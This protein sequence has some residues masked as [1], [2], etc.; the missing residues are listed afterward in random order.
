MTPLNRIKLE[1]LGSYRLLVDGQTAV[2]P[3]Y[4]KAWALLAYFALEP[5]LHARDKLVELLGIDSLAHLRQLL[6]RLR[7]MLDQPGLPAPFHT[8]HSLIGIATQYPLQCDARAFLANAGE[9]LPLVEQEARLALYRG[10]FLQG[11]SLPDAPEFETWQT[12]Q[13]EQARQQAGRLMLALQQ[14][15]ETRGQLPEAL[16]LA[17]RQVEL[18]P[19]NE[20]SHREVI[21]LLAANGQTAAALAHY[22]LCAQTLQSALNIAPGAKTQALY[23]GL[24]AGEN[25]LRDNAPPHPGDRT[26]TTEKRLITVLCLEVGSPAVTV[27]S[28][29]WDSCLS[30]M[31]AIEHLASARHTFL[32]LARQQLLDAGAYCLPEQGGRLLAYF[33]YPVARENAARQAV[34]LALELSQL[35]SQHGIDVRLGCHSALVLADGK[36]TPDMASVASGQAIQLTAQTAPGHCQISQ[37]TATL[38]QG[39]F[40]LEENP[41]KLHKGDHT[42]TVMAVTGKVHRLDAIGT[43]YPL[44]PLI[45]REQELA[46]LL[47]LWHNLPAPKAQANTDPTTKTNAVFSCLVEGE[48]GIGKSRLLRSLS[49]LVKLRQGQVIILYCQPEYAQ[50]PFQPLLGLFA[51]LSAATEN[52]PLLDRLEQLRLWMGRH[53]PERQR[54]HNETSLALLAD[55]FGMRWPQHQILLD[56]LLPQQRKDGLTTLLGDLLCGLALAQPLLL[57]VEDLHWCDPSTLDLLVR[58]AQTAPQVALL[59]VLTT[60]PHCA[61]AARLHHLAPRLVLPPLNAKEVSRLVLAVAG[62]LPATAVEHI[63]VCAE[64]VPL[65]A[66][67]MARM[68]HLDTTTM[69]ASVGSSTG[70]VALFTLQELLTARLDACGS[71]RR[72]AQLAANIGRDFS[73]KLLQQISPL[74]THLLSQELIAL[75]AAGL[76]HASSQGHYQFKHALIQDAAYASQPRSVQMTAHRRIAQALQQPITDDPAVPPEILAHHLTAAG[77]IAAALPFWRAAGQNAARQSASREAENLYQRGIALLP[78]DFDLIVNPNQR[79]ALLREAFYLCAAHGSIRLALFGYGSAEARQ[80]FARAVALSDRLELLYLKIGDPGQHQHELHNAL[81]PVLFGLWHGGGENA[82]TVAPLDLAERLSRLADSS[83]DPAQRLV[84]DYAFSHNYFWLGRYADARRHQE[85][86]IQNLHGIGSETLIALCGEDSTLLSASFLAWTLCFQGYPARAQTL[87]AETV[88]A[89]RRTE[90]THTLCY[91]LIFAGVLSRHLVQ[92]KT[93]LSYAREVTELAD[94]HSLSLWQ[95]AANALTGWALGMQGDPAGIT[96]MRRGIEL[97]RGAMRLIES[98]FRSYLVEVLAHLGQH[99]ETLVEADGALV[100]AATCHDPYLVPEFHRLKAGAMLAQTPQRLNFVRAELDTALTLARTQGNRW[101]ELRILN[102]LL[103]LPKTA[104]VD[105]RQWRTELRQHLQS[106]LDEAPA[107]AD[108]FDLQRS[109]LVLQ[110]AVRSET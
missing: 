102:D 39:F 89:A 99:A 1:T 75:E 76:I 18:D 85:A 36:Q 26:T 106:L 100:V 33:G 47:H 15:R 2:G 54:Q 56:R 27:A 71:A 13:R 30:T 109:Q 79:A 82:A 7:G 55:A 69:T 4:R 37:A 8:E 17:R 104:D 42:W 20:A 34:R 93:T 61:G 105:H 90:H 91:V 22:Q 53:L 98:T 24:L 84:A 64:G 50:T 97:C 16:V 41:D 46:L 101:F 14:A 78:T 68:T 35:A 92:P 29:P 32:Q 44:P 88:A 25:A 80:A 94:L 28:A 19:W 45:G 72:T 58:H 11:L 96:Y 81:F 107:N 40:T 57:L 43:L 65:F 31:D 6:S 60:R 95:A 5:G 23:Q 83:G 87:M 51:E 49:E 74:A 70:P 110:T 48:A 62:D 73:W 38:V 108:L 9:V 10:E 63:V 77:D 103:T 86:A 59:T 67:E 21:R 3:G 52:A 66:E 12:I